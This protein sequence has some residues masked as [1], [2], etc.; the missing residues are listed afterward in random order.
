MEPSNKT[1]AT[2]TEAE[3]R[4]DIVSAATALPELHSQTAVANS[5]SVAPETSDE[6]NGDSG[7][8]ESDEELDEE[9]EEELDEEPDEDPDG[10]PDEDPDEE[11]DE[12]LGS[13]IFDDNFDEDLKGEKM[14]KVEEELYELYYTVNEFKEDAHW[15]IARHLFLAADDPKLDD[16]AHSLRSRI[17]D[18]TGMEIV[19]LFQDAEWI[20]ECEVRRGTATKTMERV[21]AELSKLFF[22][23]ETRCYHDEARLVPCEISIR[24]QAQ[25]APQTRHGIQKETKRRSNQ[26]VGG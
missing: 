1:A 21:A 8:G 22:L 4:C 13:D 14:E 3:Q 20:F 19:A 7:E 6:P 2:Q 24:S 26:E 10:E 18:R 11:P 17:S 16:L 5:C 12:D 25:S 15:L 9:S 23:V